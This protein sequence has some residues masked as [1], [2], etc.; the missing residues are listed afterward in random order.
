MI[1]CCLAVPWAPNSGW[2]CGDR[3]LYCE[4]LPSNLLYTFLGRG[5]MH[6]YPRKVSLSILQ[7]IHQPLRLFPSTVPWRRVFARPW[8]VLRGRTTLA[9]SSS[10]LSS[11]P[12]IGLCSLW[13]SCELRRLWHAR[14]KSWP[15]SCCLLIVKENVR[16]KT[17]C[18]NYNKMLP[19]HAVPHKGGVTRDNGV[20]GNETTLM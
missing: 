8:I 4:L 7:C 13:W 9:S 20:A 6:G 18:R 17:F 1:R 3:R 15:R 16:G 2:R 5:P 19:W 10:V 14:G 11:D 12:H